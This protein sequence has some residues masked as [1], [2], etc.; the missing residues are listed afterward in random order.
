MPSYPVAGWT[1]DLAIGARKQAIGVETTIHPQGAAAHIEQHL[2]LRRAG[3]QIADAF[4]SRWLTDPA[5]AAE[6]LS[7]QIL[8]RAVRSSDHA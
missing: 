2:A 4:Q 8:K 1:V 3:W 6:M 5:G 7:R